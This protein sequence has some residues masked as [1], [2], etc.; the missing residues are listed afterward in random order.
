MNPDRTISV[1]IPTLNAAARLPD[2][3]ASL[4]GEGR[5]IEAVVVDGGSRDETVSIAAAYAGLRVVSAPGTSIYEALNRGVAAT[6]APA[7][8]FLNADDALL[9]GALSAWR[10]AL[11]RAEECGIARG[12]ATFVE[13]GPAGATVPLDRANARVAGPLS[14]EVLLRGPCAI[15]SLCIRRAVFN[16]VG[17]FDTRYRL[18]ADRDWMLRAYLAGV[19]VAEFDCPVY[20]YL[21]HAG[22]KTMD[23]SRRN[24]AQI[25]R[26]H[27]DIVARNLEGIGGQ[28]LSL[29]RALRR[30]HAAEAGMLAWHQVRAGQFRELASTL[31]DATRRAPAWP[32]ILAG[33]TIPLAGPA[34]R[35]VR[36]RHW[37]GDMGTAPIPFNYRYM[38]D[39][40]ASV[41]GRVLDYGCGIGQIVALGRARN[42]DI[43]GADTFT[44]IYSQWADA[45]DP[46]A[47]DY[48]RQIEQDRADF[49]DGHFDL[50]V[51]NQVLE[52]VTKP[53]AVISEIHRLLKP[54]GA[55][56]A[57]CP[58]VETWYEGHVGLYFAHRFKPGSPAR[59][60]YFDVS[61]RLGF[62]LYRED[63][64]R[65][66][67][68]SGS[69]KTL[70]DACFYYPR[71]RL[72]SAVEKTFAAAIEDLTVDYMR[73]R[74]GS[75]ARHLPAIADPLLSFV[76]HKRAGEIFRVRRPR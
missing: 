9:P 59:R 30:W 5:D 23:P 66:E 45:T 11:A 46:R 7:I 28:N 19:E 20:R 63:R 32:V 1:I 50:V 53:E 21:S 37:R 42:L 14:A 76:Y 3:L 62:G 41:G 71:R 47:R 74:L 26:E 40:A 56:I 52:H 27:L 43:W 2:A 70:D 25:R 29:A 49:P 60:I 22:S 18:A 73:A 12:R 35:G 51:S 15:N 44:G 16:R 34:H 72:M 64:S 68:V 48:I 67:W 24:Y 75:R 57:A 8:I 33:E 31:E 6:H 61:H 13:I 39:H 65:A 4:A 38:V 36:R 17:L 55:F 54:G 10:D 69:Q 58:A